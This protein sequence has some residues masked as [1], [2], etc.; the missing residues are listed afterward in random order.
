MSTDGRE[1]M[2]RF[3]VVTEGEWIVKDEEVEARV[4]A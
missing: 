1:I 2:N 4:T 3:M